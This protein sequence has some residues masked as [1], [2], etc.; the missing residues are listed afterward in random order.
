MIVDI[1]CKKLEE[2]VN[3]FINTEL[4]SLRIVFILVVLIELLENVDK[5][6]DYDDSIL[7]RCYFVRL[8]KIAL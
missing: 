2:D 3:D 4:A 1:K 5:K 8:R 6:Q 7:S